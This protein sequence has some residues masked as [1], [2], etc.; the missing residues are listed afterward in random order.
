MSDEQDRAAIVGQFQSQPVARRGVEV[1]RR[2]VEEEVQRAVHE[3]LRECGAHL[4]AAGELAAGTVA[5][6]GRESEASEHTRDAPVDAVPVQ[7]LVALEERALAGDQLVELLA[8][9][10]DLSGDVHQLALDGAGLGECCPELVQQ[11]AGRLEPGVLV[12]EAEVASAVPGDAGVGGLLAGN[13]AQQRRLPSA[14]RPNETDALPIADRE[15]D[16]AQHVVAA[17]G[18]GQGFGKEHASRLRRPPGSG[19]QRRTE[20][21]H[22]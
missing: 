20:G 9:P 8:A 14:V 5:V 21:E 10:F 3:H 12:M 16:I 22:G 19:Q 7:G 15:L 6:V 18:F 11:A 2:L 13:Q 4:P 17:V 1:V